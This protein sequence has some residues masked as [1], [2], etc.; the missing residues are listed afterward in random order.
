MPYEP[1]RANDF[2]GIIGKRIRASSFENIVAVSEL[3]GLN[4]IEGT[5][6]SFV[7]DNFNVSGFSTLIFSQKLL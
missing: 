1:C 4:Q 7:I 5:Y 6:F 2:C 3:Y